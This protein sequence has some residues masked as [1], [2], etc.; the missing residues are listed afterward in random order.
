M[1][2]TPFCLAAVAG[3]LLCGPAV[4]HPIVAATTPVESTI[5]G[6]PWTLAQGPASNA[7]PYNGYCVN[8]TPA[9]NPGTELMQ[10]YYFP[11]VQGSGNFLQGYFDYR[12]RNANEAV[13]AAISTDGG[14]R[15]RFQQLSAALSTACPTD[16]LNPDNPTSPGGVFDNGQGHPYVLDF[17]TYRLLY[18]LDRSA[19]DIDVTGLIVHE[20][21][22]NFAHPLR[23]VPAVEPVPER[24]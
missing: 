19:S 13:A 22:A 14:K 6:G 12:P 23:G 24:R 1:K 8:G 7:V 21:R 5:S 20:L 17:D 11:H 18:T 9:R 16:P 15:W 4:A 10:P 3:G 2:T